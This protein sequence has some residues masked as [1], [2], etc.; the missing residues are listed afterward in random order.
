MKVEDEDWNQSSGGIENV[1]HYSSSTQNWNSFYYIFDSQRYRHKESLL[2]I[3]VSYLEEADV[4][5]EMQVC[6]N[7]NNWNRFKVKNEFIHL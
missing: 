4:L 7:L 2:E 5:H 6:S 1:L 3:K